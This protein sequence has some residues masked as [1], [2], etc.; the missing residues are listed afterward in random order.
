[1]AYI[2]KKQLVAQTYPQCDLQVTV[3]GAHNTTTQAPRTWNPPILSP[4]AQILAVL[5]EIEEGLA[6]F[7]QQQAEF[8]QGQDILLQG[9]AILRQQ[10]VAI[11]QSID[12]I[13]IG[14]NR[15]EQGV[16]ALCQEVRGLREDISRRYI[17][18][19]TFVTCSWVSRDSQ[20]EI[21]RY[22]EDREEKRRWKSLQE[23]W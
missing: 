17:F 18:L 22:Y 4:G 16:D 21:L 1:M 19:I 10:T 5:H 11:S 23:I 7:R 3:Q 8:R 13:E 2:K 9:L 12:H 20:R 14:V 6:V 15:L